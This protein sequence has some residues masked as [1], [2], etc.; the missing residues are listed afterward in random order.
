MA[1]LCKVAAVYERCTAEVAAL[2]STNEEMN[3][4][5]VYPLLAADSLDTAASV[6]VKITGSSVFA[7]VGAATADAILSNT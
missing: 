4:S 2:G 5:A 7:G 6:P 3:A 1:V